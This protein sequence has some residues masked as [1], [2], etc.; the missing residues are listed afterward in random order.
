MEGCLRTLDHP[1]L[2]PPS[3]SLLDADQRGATC[4]VFSSS[5]KVSSDI[6][7]VSF[8]GTVGGGGKCNLG[9]RG[10]G[11]G[12]VCGGGFTHGG[13]CES[14]ITSAWHDTIKKRKTQLIYYNTHQHHQHTKTLTPTALVVWIE[15][16][17]TRGTRKKQQQRDACGMHNVWAPRKAF[18][19]QR[20]AAN[21]K[22]Q[23]ESHLLWE[24]EKRE[25]EARATRRSCLVQ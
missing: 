6:A 1:R 9:C 4:T 12:W 15:K 20:S 13:A 23:A 19:R 24:R 8:D 7:D 18:G 10:R 21:W 16:Q 11:R 14:H 3:S 2:P 17:K 22:L 5:G 25:R